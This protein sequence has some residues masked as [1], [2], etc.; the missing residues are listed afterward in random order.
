MECSCVAS[1]GC[2]EEA[3]NYVQAKIKAKKDYTCSECNGK[4]FTGEKYIY[5]TVFYDG[6]VYHTRLC[7]CCDSLAEHF[8]PD[9]WGYQG[10][11]L[12]ELE[13][14]LFNAWQEDLP[15][16]CISKLTPAARDVVCDIL[17][18]FQEG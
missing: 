3:D 18:G 15:S 11:M 12:A 4:I 9:G 8:F 16:D 1:S 17:Q 5:T 14:Y 6:D 10:D 2:G 7:L 13:D